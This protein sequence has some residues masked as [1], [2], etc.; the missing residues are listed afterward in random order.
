MLCEIVWPAVIQ[1]V[2]SDPDIY[3]RNPDNHKF[4]AMR[5]VQGEYETVYSSAIKAALNSDSMVWRWDV[6]WCDAGSPDRASTTK[7]MGVFNQ[8]FFP[9]QINYT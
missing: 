8:S 5:A 6:V 2:M 3:L 1:T 4:L 7:N 9:L